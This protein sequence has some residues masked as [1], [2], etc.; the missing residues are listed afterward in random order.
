MSLKGFVKLVCSDRDASHGYEHAKNVAANAAKICDK[1][2]VSENIRKLVNICAWLHDI[3]DHKYDHADRIYDDHADRI[4]GDQRDG[5]LHRVL[6]QFLRDNYPSNVQLILAIIE[7]ISFSRQIREG[8]DDWMRVLGEEGTLVRNI[9]SDADKLEAINLQRAIDY[10]K[11][12]FPSISNKALAEEVINHA[13][14]KLLRLKDEF[15]YYAKEEAEVLHMRLI[16]D[17][18]VIRH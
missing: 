7:R 4:Y 10:T 12:R 14:E 1:L 9:V 18:S 2:Q 11:H 15:I 13:N 16:T 8:T 6:T 17:I 5:F 3:A